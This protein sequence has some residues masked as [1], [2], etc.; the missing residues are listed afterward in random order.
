MRPVSLEIVQGKG[1]TIE[2]VVVRTDGSPLGDTEIR[3]TNSTSFRD[4][5]R[6]DAQGR[7]RFDDLPLGAPISLD[8]GGWGFRTRL[9]VASGEDFVR[10]EVDPKVE[11]K[12]RVL[13]PQGQPTQEAHVTLTRMGESGIAF[14]DTDLQGRFR[15]EVEPGEYLLLASQQPY[16]PYESVLRAD[17]LEKAPPSVDIVLQPGMTAEGAIGDVDSSRYFSVQV[18]AAW[19]GRFKSRD[20]GVPRVGRV[21]EDG[22]VRIPGMGPGA[23]RIDAYDTGADGGRWDDAFTLLV[24]PGQKFI[25]LPFQHKDGGRID[26]VLRQD[27]R[28]LA[29]VRVQLMTVGDPIAGL[30]VDRWTR[31]TSREGSAAF[32]G[33]RPADYKV[34]MQ[35]GNF[36]LGRPVEVKRRRRHKVDVDLR[37]GHLRGVVRGR[38]GLGVSQARIVLNSVKGSDAQGTVRQRTDQAGAFSVADLPRGEYSLRVMAEGYPAKARDLRLEDAS[39]SIE[40]QLD[41][42]PPIHLEVSPPAGAPRE[43]LFVTVI[44]K[45]SA[46][47]RPYLQF[48]S[49]EFSVYSE[50][51]VAMSVSSALYATALIPHPVAGKTY[52]IALQKGGEVTFDVLAREGEV[53]PKTL[54]PIFR[55]A[56]PGTPYKIHLTAPDGLRWGDYMP[57]SWR[58]SAPRQLGRLKLGTWKY[59][60]QFS[61]G[62]AKSGA[63][64]A[65]A[66]RS[67]TVRVVKDDNR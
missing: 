26:L 14:S 65:V 45:S 37:T 52:K 39:V 43:K 24:E 61:D 46:D 33:L 12:G 7:F 47:P 58:T 38:D 57:Y 34:F 27:G 28:T 32:V 15:V 9:N 11:V 31:W 55:A 8:T 63:F 20:G 23:W 59:E 21:G 53:R 17:A 41:A 35:V 30:D 4:S 66:D 6:S 1:R 60:V 62:T 56:A 48:V 40:V 44:P 36:Y 2:G 42:V 67:V 19:L 16:A 29:G 3:L 49:G 5:T 13:D 18:S 10:L 64:E 54:R 25:E 50:P 51:L 22:M